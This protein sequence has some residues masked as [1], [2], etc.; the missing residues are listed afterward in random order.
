MYLALKLATFIFSR[1]LPKYF[2]YAE[3]SITTIEVV[4]TL[5]PWINF[6]KPIFRR[7]R[8]SGKNKLVVFRGK[9][10]AQCFPV[11]PKAM[12]IILNNLFV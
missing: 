10:L 9:L 11:R 12:V 5:A 3:T 1:C 8:C 6:Y 2:T 7:H 4:I